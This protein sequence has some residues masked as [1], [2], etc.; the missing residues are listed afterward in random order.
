MP[1][2]WLHQDLG[3]APVLLLDEVAAHLDE[4]RRA[5]LYDEIC[6]LGAQAVMT[7]TDSA[8]FDALGPRGQVLS[9]SDN[10][11]GSCIGTE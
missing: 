7:G 4:T 1:V 2:R 6:A 10:G 9:V 8:L 11:A 5:A 3:R